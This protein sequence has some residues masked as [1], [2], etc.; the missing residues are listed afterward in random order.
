MRDLRYAPILL[1][2]ETRIVAA[3]IVARSQQIELTD[4]QVRSALRKL[5]LLAKGER[6]SIASDKPRERILAGLVVT[7]SDARTSLGFSQGDAKN[8]APLTATVWINALTTIVD[9]IHTRTA[10]AGSRAY[11]DFVG[12]FVKEAGL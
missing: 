2:I 12:N 9:S 11:L 6:P 5:V 7:L 4:S 10:G 8:P 1:E 3:D